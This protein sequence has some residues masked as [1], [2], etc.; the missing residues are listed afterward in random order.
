MNAT[1]GADPD[2]LDRLAAQMDAWATLLARHRVTLNAHIHSAPWRGQEA[3]RFRQTWNSR[4]SPSLVGSVNALHAA[5]GSLKQNAAQQRQASAVGN[6]NYPAPS[7]YSPG[8][9]RNFYAQLG[10]A[11]S[12]HKALPHFMLAIPGMA[13]LVK[14]G[15]SQALS[16]REESAAQ[17]QAWWNSLSPDEQNA[18]VLA[19]PEVLLGFAPSALPAAVYASAT[20]QFVIEAHGNTL[21]STADESTAA[22][23]KVAT[24]DVKGEGDASMN[25]YEDG[26]ATVT[27]GLEGGA[28]REFGSKHE[29]AGVDVD[30]GVQST[31]TFRNAADAQSFLNGLQSRILDPVAAVGYLDQWSTNRIDTTANL[32]LSGNAHINIDGQ[33]VEVSG[34]AGGTYDLDSHASTLYVDVRGSDTMGGLSGGVDGRLA[35]SVDASGHV[36][37]ATFSGTAHAT[38]SAGV[39]AVIHQ[40]SGQNIPLASASTSNGADVSFSA[41]VDPGNPAVR[42]ALTQLIASP[43]DTQAMQSLFAHSDATVQVDS[44][45]DATSTFNLG[46]LSETHDTATSASVLAYAKPVD[47]GWINVGP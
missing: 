24:W 31:Y 43:S 36:T 19:H 38:T 35:V 9:W 13:W 29:G 28:G 7:T 46:P 10:A 44:T 41:T 16:V 3:D 6:N 37:S 20:R 25:V 27:V 21:R 14:S 26:H 2:A 32:D 15:Y 45:R 40:V 8:Q 23:L 33:R 47:G 22:S 11:E 4:L 42:A 34:A 12:G 18:M 17:Q 39:E 1:W 30:A 5:Q